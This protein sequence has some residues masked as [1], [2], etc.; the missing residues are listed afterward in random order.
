MKPAP[1]VSP[2]RAAA[3]HILLS[4]DSGKSF[5]IDLLQADAVAR[6]SELDRHLTMELVMG[7][8][9]WRGDLDREIE[10][11]SGK[12]LSR[13][14]AE[15]VAILRLGI[16]QIR[17]LTKIPK[18]AAVNESVELTRLARKRSAAGLV[19]A[20]LRKS[21]PL[22]DPGLDGARLAAV[23]RSVPSWLLDRWSAH[24][25]AEAAGRLAQASVETP[26]TTLRIVGGSTRDEVQTALGAEGITSA[27]MA[28]AERALAVE[29]G[30]VTASAAYRQG[31][32][33]IQD[34]ASQ[35]VGDLVRSAAGD[36]VLD[37]CAAPGGKA[38]QFAER[39]GSG[40]LLV[41]GD[42][43][44]RRLAT[45]SGLLSGKSRVAC[46]P[47]NL[48]RLDAR[49]PLPFAA[50]FDRVLVDAPCSGTGTL[51]RN[52]EIKWRL[53][54]DDIPR[55]A[56]TQVA[57]L[58][59]ALDALAP[60]GRLVYATCSLEPEEN[61]GVVEEVLAQSPRWRL[62]NREELMREFPRLEPL[63]DSHGYF[64]TRPDRDRMDGFFAAVLV[65]TAGAGA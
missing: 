4:V 24:F 63:F 42:L 57:I 45:I 51:A 11:L 36:R 31:L 5:A 33:R 38:S 17:H 27:P 48:V 37:L 56:E 19:N 50:V 61:E 59:N 1:Q 58:A 32:I 16:Y 52:P 18:W 44:A 14:D 47:P 65:S 13:F 9:R 60:G 49:R 6:L 39:L 34:Q 3:Y 22:V 15:L 41:A 2:A 10:R 12:A 26:A 40:G 53:Q 43:S 29:S 28:Y 21:G 46:C 64:R 62:M 8:L 7:V 23:R 35:L 20:V 55:L 30:D 25:G 54:L